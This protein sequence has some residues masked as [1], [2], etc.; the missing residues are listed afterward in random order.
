MPMSH[1]VQCKTIMRCLH[2][3]IWFGPLQS[4]CDVNNPVNG[5]RV[6]VIRIESVFTSNEASYP[7]IYQIDDNDFML[8]S[9]WN[10]LPLANKQSNMSF[11]TYV[12]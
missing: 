5:R 9:I 7:E 11:N 8:N 3:S 10:K 2:L 12:W 6:L 4:L 1:P